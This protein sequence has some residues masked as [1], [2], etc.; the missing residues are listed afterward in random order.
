MTPTIIPDYIGR[1]V[2]PGEYGIL[3]YSFGGGGGSPVLAL[4]LYEFDQLVL[5]NDGNVG[6][7]TTTPTH[8]LTVNG[9]ASNPSGQWTVS[10]DARLKQHIAPLPAQLTRLLRLRGVTYEWREPEKH[11]GLRGP[12]I[13][14]IAQE[15]E[16]V[17]PEWVGTDAEGYKTLTYRGFE[18]I[19]VESLREL[20]AEN[21]ELKGELDALKERLATLENGPALQHASVA[22]DARWSFAVLLGAA[23]GSAPLWWRRRRAKAAP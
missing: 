11:G 8:L 5:A 14:M 22:P 4:H 7:G 18:A 12:Q 10:S 3:E 16:E 17:F 2:N 23:L 20:K 19:T 9:S 15:V 1:G 13:G 6:I 21:T